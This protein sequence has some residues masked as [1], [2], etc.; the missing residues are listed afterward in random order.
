VCAPGGDIYPALKLGCKAS[1]AR[2]IAAIQDSKRIRESIT[3]FRETFRIRGDMG[4]LK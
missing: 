1:I 3:A 4:Y 2:E